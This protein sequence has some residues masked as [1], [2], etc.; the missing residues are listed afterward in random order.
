MEESSRE[1]KRWKA[2]SELQRAE[3]DGEAHGHKH[4]SGEEAGYY[5]LYPTSGKQLSVL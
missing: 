3:E 5:S 4:L 2:Q 1:I